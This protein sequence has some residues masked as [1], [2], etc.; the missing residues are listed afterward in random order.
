MFMSEDS[1]ERGFTRTIFTKLEF[2]WRISLSAAI[3]S[4]Y[5]SLVYVTCQSHFDFLFDITK[6]SNFTDRIQLVY[7]ISEDFHRYTLKKYI[8]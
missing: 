7:S 4:I 8:Q 5:I 1:K 6:L 3:T 2:V